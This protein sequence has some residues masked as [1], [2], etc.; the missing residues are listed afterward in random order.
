MKTRKI[1][2]VDFGTF[3]DF[4]TQEVVIPNDVVLIERVLGFLTS[5]TTPES[6]I[7]NVILRV[8]YPHFEQKI[9]ILVPVKVNQKVRLMQDAFDVNMPVTHS[10]SSIKIKSVKNNDVP[11][12]GKLAVYLICKRRA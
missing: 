7:D 10:N 6:N 2:K 4:E 9:T 3:S 5:K 1:I 8:Y 11:T 12:D